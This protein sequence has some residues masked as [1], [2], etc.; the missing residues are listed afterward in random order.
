MNNKLK[1]QFTQCWNPIG[2]L[3]KIY[4]NKTVR[5]N[6]F[7]EFAFNKAIIEKEL[8]KRLLL[9]VNGPTAAGKAYLA[10]YISLLVLSIRTN[11]KAIISVPQ[12]IIAS[13]FKGPHNLSYISGTS[14]NTIFDTEDKAWAPSNYLFDYSEKSNTDA[15]RRFLEKPGNKKDIND[16]ILVCTHATLV[17]AYNSFPELFKNLFVCI[18]EAHKARSQYGT[19]DETGLSISDCNKLGEF[20]SDCV[21]HSELEND[22]LLTSATFFRSDSTSIIPQEQIDNFTK[23]YYPMDEYLKNCHYL[24]SLSYEFGIYDFLWGDL[25]KTVIGEHIDNGGKPIV[26]IPPVGSIYSY[27]SKFDDVRKVYEAISGESNP[28]IV[29]EKSGIT[30]IKRGKKWIKVVNLVEDE[31]MHLRNKRKKLIEEAH[32]HENSDKIDAIVTLRIMEEGANWKWADCLLQLGIIGSMV[33]AVQ[34]VGRVLRDAE[35][36]ENVRIVQ[37]VPS[38]VDTNDRNKFRDAANDLVKCVLASMIIEDMIMPSKFKIANECNGSKK[39]GN[40]NGKANLLIDE[41][42]EQ[43]YIEIMGAILE[44][45]VIA[46]DNGEVCFGDGSKGSNERFKNVVISVLE[47]Y[48]VVSNH[49]TIAEQIRRA[50]VVRAMKRRGGVDM[51]NVDFDVVSLSV[52]PLEMWLTAYSETLGIDTFAKLRKAINNSYVSFDEWKEW[53]SKNIAWYLSGTFEKGDS[54]RDVLRKYGL[55]ANGTVKEYQGRE[56]PKRPDFIHHNPW[57]FYKELRENVERENKQTSI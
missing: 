39:N 3:P 46:Q 24:K 38:N 52:N 32:L 41:V 45:A 4:E 21:T 20:I 30:R 29:E 34:R 7:Q 1:N 47:D 37:F 35:G 15:V 33:V 23:I 11:K 26:Y 53:V 27:G 9:I 14:G 19:D 49:E 50:W 18:D 42:G 55:W 36:K 10:Q 44:R 17:M 16:R 40:G 57:G 54:H 12:T 8:P 25:L 43:K 48:N 28:E 22:L 5:M 31:D 2:E 13:G 56:L 51:N 6:P